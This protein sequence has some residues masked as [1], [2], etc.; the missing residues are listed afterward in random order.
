M[1]TLNE[2]RN[3]AEGAI[4]WMEDFCYIPIHPPG[5]VV[6]KWVRLGDLPKGV[7]PKTGKAYSKIWNGQKEVLREALQMKDGEFIYRLIVFCWMRGEGKSLLA[8]LIQL[9]KFFCWPRQQIMLG[10]NSRDQVKFVHFDII[11][12]IIYNSPDLLR[13]IGGKKNLQEKEVRLKD[14][15]GHVRS[16]IRSISSFSGIVS[17]ITGYTFSEI[18]DMKNPR[19]FVQLDGSIRNIPNALGVIDSTVSEKTHVLYDLYKGFIQGKLKTVYFSYRSS[20]TANPD[21]YWNPNMDADQLNDYK[22]KFPFGEFERYFMNSWSAGRIRVLTDEMIEET[23]HIGIDNTFLDH[24]PLVK[25]LTKRL[26][27][28]DLMVEISSK[29]FKVDN[30]GEQQI[31][32]DQIT[33][34]LMPVENYYKLINRYG[35]NQMATM[36][37]LE[38]L[39]EI[40]DTDWGIIAGLDMADPMAKRGQAR[41]ILTVAA[42]GLPGS[43]SRPYMVAIGD[44]APKY[45]YFMLYVFNNERHKTD[46]IKIEIDA[47]CTE[48]DGIDILCAERYG[49]WDISEWCEDR[50]IEYQAVYPT[51]NLQREAFKE[52]FTVYD[53]GRIKCPP[54]GITGVKKDLIRE[55]AEVFDHD[56]DKRW[57]GSPEKYE[58][59]GVQDDSVYSTGWMLY[60]GRFMTVDDFRI[61]KSFSNFGD[62]YKN[63]SLVAK[64]T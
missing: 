27:I 1:T 54:I 20:K 33:D 6:S 30:L 16:L 26:E 58:K 64:Y 8:C 51:Y 62:F 39:G 48:Y 40:L 17:N 4:Q 34:R 42:K 5:E 29:G 44:T 55:E 9:W 31:K 15:K 19:F 63:E 47:C 52:L 57:F 45:I 14:N 60:G 46:Q 13:L 59:Y 32:I 35:S 61:R 53:E 3:G 7:N 38:K 2:Y 41:T 11:R 36:E 12:D 49:A 50:S 18:F 10:A 25:S 24:K 23:Y 56:P 37:D 22:V 28:R 43:K 21:D